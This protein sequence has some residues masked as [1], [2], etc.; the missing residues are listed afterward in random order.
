MEYY[1]CF[2]TNGKNAKKKWKCLGSFNYHLS[3][4]HMGGSNNVTQVPSSLL[5]FTVRATTIKK[6]KKIS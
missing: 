1:I 3:L 5:V 6:K 4:S 2:G